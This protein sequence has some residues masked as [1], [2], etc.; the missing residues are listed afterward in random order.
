LSTETPAQSAR[1]SLKVWLTQMNMKL[2]KKRPPGYI[3]LCSLSLIIKSFYVEIM[4]CLYPFNASSPEFTKDNKSKTE[5]VPFHI[6]L[7]PFGYNR[8]YKRSFDDV[9]VTLNYELEQCAVQ[10]SDAD[11]ILYKITLILI[12]SIFDNGKKLLEQCEC[13]VHLYIYVNKL[14]NRML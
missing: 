11:D 10:K 9:Q 14:S 13:T 12:T 6:H 1:E 4:T 8:H 3:C 2:A 5:R 7:S